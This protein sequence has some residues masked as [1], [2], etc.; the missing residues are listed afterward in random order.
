MMTQVDTAHLTHKTWKSKY[1]NK[2]SVTLY[3]QPEEEEGC[4]DHTSLD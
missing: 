2:D 3:V 1:T 4:Y